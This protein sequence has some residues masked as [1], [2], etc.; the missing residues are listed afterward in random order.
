MDLRQTAV[1]TLSCSTGSR[2]KAEADRA[3]AKPIETGVCERPRR[4]GARRGPRLDQRSSGPVGGGWST[5]KTAFVDAKPTPSRFPADGA[6]KTWSGRFRLTQAASRAAIRVQIGS[7]N[8]TS[9]SSSNSTELGYG[10]LGNG[11][12]Y[13]RGSMNSRPI[14]VGL[15]WHCLGH[16]NLGVDALTRANFLL[17]ENAAGRIGKELNVITL[18][19]GPLPAEESIPAN[20]TTSAR[21]RI[22]PF[23]RGWSEYLTELHRCDLVL[24]IGEG[25]S[26]TDIYGT[27]RLTY[28]TVTKLAAI[29]L[30]KPLVLAPQTIGPFEHVAARP[31]ADFVMN[32]CRAVYTRDHLSTDYLR[33]RRVR[34]RSAEFIDVAFA[35]P[36]TPMPRIGDGFNVG[37]NV[38]GLLYRGGYTGRNELGMTLDYAALTHGLIKGLLARKNTNVYL[39]A[40]VIGDTGNDCDTTVIPELQARYPALRTL[41]RFA[42]ASDA[43]SHISGLDFIIAGRMH[44]C[45]AALSAGVP[46]L[47]ISYS[48]KFNGLFDSLG[49][50]HYINGK[51]IDTDR[52]II[53][54]LGAVDRADDLKADVDHAILEAQRRVSAYTDTLATLLSELEIT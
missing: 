4:T 22:K 17:L 33:E 18:G 53:C 16:P 50:P 14:R 40:H 11:S 42:N 45:I 24:D 47:A 44:A 8:M 29:A 10:V 38:S 19:S 26:W 52:A 25:D 41:P 9:V 31:I 20:L 1:N 15:A 46:T 43:K 32:R 27:K 39:V 6:N 21:F 28:Q 54:A 12:S 2:P 34:A 51:S 13:V 3:S 35:L 49:Y 48:R 37:I 30:G 36:H 5:A 7:R 23:P